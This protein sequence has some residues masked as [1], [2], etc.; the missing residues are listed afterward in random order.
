MEQF[1]N[2]T[3]GKVYREF[4]FENVVAYQSNVFKELINTDVLIQAD[5][6]IMALQFYAPIYLLLIAYDENNSNENKILDDLT[7]HVKLFIKVYSQRK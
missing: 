5:C 2:E 7:N 6:K 1:R 4:Y 3:L